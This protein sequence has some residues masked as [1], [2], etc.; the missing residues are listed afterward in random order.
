MKKY[1]IIIKIKIDMS[2][3][4]VKSEIYNESVDC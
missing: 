4:I 2:P 1:K 3:E